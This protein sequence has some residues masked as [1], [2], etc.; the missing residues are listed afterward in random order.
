MLMG[1]DVPR[2]EKKETFGTKG[3]TT[4]TADGLQLKADK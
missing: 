2:A 3:F 4:Q 1:R